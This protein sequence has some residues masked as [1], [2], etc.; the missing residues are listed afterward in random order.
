MR[1][2][3][4][5]VGFAGIAALVGIQ[6]YR[7]G[8]LQ[9]NQPS[10]EHY[11]IT[12][13]DVSHHQGEIDWAAVASSGMQFAFIKATEGS[14][15]VDRQF[16]AN[17]RSATHAGIP[18]GPYHFFTF[19]APGVAQAENFLRVAPPTSTS[20]PPVADVEFV[21]NCRSWSDASV[22]RAELAVF[23]G[24]VERSWGSKPIL[25]VTPEA[26]ER[27]L[28][29]QFHGHPI[30]I[31]SVF[32][33]PDLGAYRGWRIWQFSDNSRVPGIRGPVDRNALR[34]GLDLNQLRQPAG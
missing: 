29:D 33:E 20:L 9:F 34:P 11:P 24:L 2:L 8:A 16:A 31:R 22:V 30:W 23:L 19:C 10:F 3:F 12:G 27:I 26:L 28:S 7:S 1:I 13:I 6:L 14:D 4:I 32:S 15:H 5:A 18:V 25:Y 17:W 21:G